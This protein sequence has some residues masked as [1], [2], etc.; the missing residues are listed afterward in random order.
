[1]TA[2]MEASRVSCRTCIESHSYTALHDLVHT[3]SVVSLQLAAIALCALV[4]GL[5][6]RQATC[7]QT[8]CWLHGTLIE[9]TMLADYI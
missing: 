4:P 9:Q 3:C 7:K 1:V 8:T 5:Q 2:D 6:S